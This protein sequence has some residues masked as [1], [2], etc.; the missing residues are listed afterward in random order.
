ML[1]R[2]LLQSC[3]R[4]GGQR[5]NALD[6]RTGSSSLHPRSESSRQKETE[7]GEEPRLKKTGRWSNVFKPRNIRDRETPRV[8]RII[9][10]LRYM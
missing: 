5:Q 9:S 3:R 10:K 8:G 4:I 7:C 6:S 1:L 2:L